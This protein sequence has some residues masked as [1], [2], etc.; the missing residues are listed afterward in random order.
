VRNSFFIFSISTALPTKNLIGTS[1]SSDEVLSELELICTLF[2]EL[3]CTL[4]EELACTLVEELAC[5]LVEE[6]A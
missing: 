4:V 5:T 2:E 3:A 1:A 6:L